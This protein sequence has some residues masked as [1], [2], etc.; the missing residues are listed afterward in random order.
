MQKKTLLWLTLQQ[1]NSPAENQVAAE[2]TFDFTW[3]VS[4]KSFAFELSFENQ[5]SAEQTF[6]LRE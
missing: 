2:Q 3:L 6:D 4:E 5:A 1:Y